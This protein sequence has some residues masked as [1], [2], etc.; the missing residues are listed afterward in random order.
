MKITEENDIREQNPYIKNKYS[1]CSTTWQNMPQQYTELINSITAICPKLVLT[2]Q[3]SFHVLGIEKYDFHQRKP[4]LDFA[5]TEPLTSEDIDF[6]K[7]FFNLK[8]LDRNG[9]IV[10]DSNITLL[11]GKL[12]SF[13]YKP[14]TPD[15]IIID[16]FTEQ[17]TNNLC[18]LIPVITS[19]DE[20]PYI[21]YVQHPKIAISHKALY[22]FTE[23]Y[24]K[25]N[26]HKDDLIDLLC[27][28]YGIFTKK[29]DFMS[30]LR[31][32]YL[33]FLENKVEKEVLD[34]K[35]PF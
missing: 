16:I 12:I 24:H 1:Y 9:Y 27:K 31:S 26:K 14:A 4:D 15:E 10:D 34:I 17:I 28:N 6:L 11:K 25:K 35:L 29:M 20:D 32:N 23:N 7:G 33:F 30:S 18:N 22:A 5:L 21:I 8:V 3:L 2:G 13:I 19:N